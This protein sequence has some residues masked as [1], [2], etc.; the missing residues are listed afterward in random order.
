[1]E[2]AG[3]SKHC[4]SNTFRFT[5]IQRRKADGRSPDPGTRK[6]CGKFHVMEGKI[7]V[8]GASL[9]ISTTIW[10][11]IFHLLSGFLNV[12]P[13]RESIWVF[14]HSL[15]LFY[16]IGK[17][18]TL[19]QFFKWQHLKFYHRFQHP[20]SVNIYLLCMVSLGIADTSISINIYI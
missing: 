4:M 7:R 10:F 1:M 15:P 9:I 6:C 14:C 3:N 16:V 19:F 12:L 20:L 17:L 11:Y 5:L 2:E 18:Y 13:F 8:S